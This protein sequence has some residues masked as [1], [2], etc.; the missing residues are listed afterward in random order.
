MP[1]SAGE[2]QK[3]HRSKFRPHSLASVHPDIPQWMTRIDFTG[4]KLWLLTSV[5]AISGIR[6]LDVFINVSG[7]SDRELLFH[8]TPTSASWL[9][10]V[11]GFFATLAKR[12]LK[13]GVFRSVADLQAT[14]N[15]FLDNQQHPFQTLRMG[16]RSRQNYRRRQTRAS[17][18][19]FDPL[20][21]CPSSGGIF[22]ANLI[23]FAT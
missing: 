7:N 6:L 12:R 15:R 23:P 18:V 22:A 21:A 3:R 5:I 2:S 1:D 11:E 16:R 13:R 20:G 10:A 17:S 14:I 4:S 9:N 8:F 19:R